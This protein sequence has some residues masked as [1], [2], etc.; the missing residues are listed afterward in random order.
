M[1]L[2]IPLLF[3]LSPNA[4]LVADGISNNLKPTLEVL[5]DVQFEGMFNILRDFGWNVDTVT[6]K[7]GS[8][9][10]GRY[11]DKV[12][13]HGKNNS[14]CIVVTQDQELIKRCRTQGVKVIGLEMDDLAKLVNQVLQKDYS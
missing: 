14:N 8:T 9:K 3:L 10:E 1:G 6:K 13:E 12:V 7:W 2:T 5:L 11:D 4:Y